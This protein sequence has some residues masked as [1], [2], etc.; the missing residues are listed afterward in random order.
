MR[1]SK[2]MCLGQA[3]RG[4]S[5]LQGDLEDAGGG[6]GGEGDGLGDGLVQVEAPQKLV[7]D[8]DLGSPRPSNQQHRLHE[9]CHNSS[10]HPR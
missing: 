3:K 8:V 10:D 7:G 2:A 4:V 9:F 5:R 1:G 6:E